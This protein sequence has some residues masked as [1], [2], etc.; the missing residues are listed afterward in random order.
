MDLN[1]PIEQN[2]LNALC[3][4]KKVTLVSKKLIGGEKK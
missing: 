3:E 1:L 4:A 2:V